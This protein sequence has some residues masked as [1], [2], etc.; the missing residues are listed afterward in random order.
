[1]V[2]VPLVANRVGAVM[3]GNIISL[4]YCLRLDQ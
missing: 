1:M 4:K 3:C 2:G